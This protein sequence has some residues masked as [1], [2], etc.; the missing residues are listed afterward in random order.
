LTL[1]VRNC[2]TLMRLRLVGKSENC[3]QTVQVT[4]Y[5]IL[6]STPDHEEL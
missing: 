4:V 6:I 5:C 3:Q 2:I 1:D